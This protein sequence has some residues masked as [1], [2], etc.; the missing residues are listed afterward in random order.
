LCGAKV[1]RARS[2]LDLKA[3]TVAE[4]LRCANHLLAK[5]KGNGDAEKNLCFTDEKFFRLGGELNKYNMVYY[6]DTNPN[7]KIAKGNH[8]CGVMTCCAVTS[9][10]LIGPIFPEGNINAVKYQNMLEMEFLPELRKRTDP[11]KAWF[12]QDGARTRTA[13][14]TIKFLNKHFC[15]H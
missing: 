11:S 9:K 5:L 15:T 3:G 14:S 4:R 2:R 12:Q 13:A 6:S 8:Y 1:C 7:Y 10:E